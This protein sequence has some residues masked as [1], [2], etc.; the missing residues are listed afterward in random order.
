MAD[1]PCIS[2]DSSDG[3]EP[4]KNGDYCFVCHQK[5]FNRRLKLENDG[6][7]QKK[8]K[9][10]QLTTINDYWINY[11]QQR[12]VH[13][14][15][16]QHFNI[17]FDELSQSIAFPCCK[18]SPQKILGYQLRDKN[19]KIK[20][21]RFSAENE[22]FLFELRVDNI[23]DLVIVEDPVSALRIWQDAKMNCISLLGTNLSTENKLYIIENYRDVV[24]WMDGDDAGYKA[25]KK[26]VRDLS[27]YLYVATRFTRDDPKDLDHHTINKI[28]ALD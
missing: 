17:Q 11:L 12:G 28:L 27:P 6:K 26:I 9:K 2:C 18:Q 21:V 24:V 16:I 14:K 25:A 15:T 10:I 20:T 7:K 22:P 3:V 4:Y 13:E 23:Q 5:F 19:K 1:L 8:P